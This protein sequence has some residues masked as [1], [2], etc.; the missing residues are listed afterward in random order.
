MAIPF[1]REDSQAAVTAAQDVFVRRCPTCGERNV[2]RDGWFAC[3]SCGADLPAAW[4]FSR[5][6]T[7]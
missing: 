7:I 4:N 6:G 1:G 3:G 2:I 5:E